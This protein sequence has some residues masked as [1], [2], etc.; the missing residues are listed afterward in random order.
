MSNPEP[1]VEGLQAE[2]DRLNAELAAK[3]E[4]TGNV[5][6]ANV[7]A[8]SVAAVREPT[9]TAIGA[10]SDP[11]GGFVVGYSDGTVSLFDV[12][13]D[14]GEAAEPWGNAEEGTYSHF[15]T[16]ENGEVYNFV[17]DSVPAKV[18]SVSKAVRAL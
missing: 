1:T 4:G 18:V 17:D 2:I 15:F 7:T 16:T 14:N 12:P 13:E 11:R 8:T 9:G 3:D 6:P 5:T 10:A